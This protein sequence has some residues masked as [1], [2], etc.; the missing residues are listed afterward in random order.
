MVLQLI[1]QIRDGMCYNPILVGALAQGQS[2]REC[3]TP[4]GTFEKRWSGRPK[5]KFEKPMKQ[6]MPAPMFEE[7]TFPTIQSYGQSEYKCSQG[8]IAVCG[9]TE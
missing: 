5:V 6:R 4:K 8:F 1:L 7:K 9:K 2:V 3:G